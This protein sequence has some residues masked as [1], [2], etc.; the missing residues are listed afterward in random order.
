MFS[1]VQEIVDRIIAEKNARAE[2]AGLTSTSNVAIY[3]IWAYCVAVV[4]YVLDQF[5]ESHKLEVNAKLAARVSHGTTWYAAK[6]LEFQYGD[7]IE[8]VNYVPTYPVIDESKRI[9]KKVAAIDNF[10]AMPIK[11]AQEVSGELVKLDDAQLLAAN[12]YLVK[13]KDAGVNTILMSFD[14]DL[15]RPKLEIYYDAQ[16]PKATIKASVNAAIIAYLKVYNDERFNG[17]FEVIHFIDAMQ[18][19][20]GLKDIVPV[21]MLFKST[22][23]PG[24]TNYPRVYD[25]E[26]GYLKV[27]PAYDLDD[28]L[29][30]IKYFA[31]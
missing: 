11:V 31:Q 18:E 13:F 3:K 25:P 19:V 8:L 12:A 9:I 26:S 15:F 30:N 10:G 17:R 29:L 21:S 6:M 22:I 28:E 14:A 7:T 2:L 24:F 27:D 4:I 16:I 5:F 20:T 1:G 23:A